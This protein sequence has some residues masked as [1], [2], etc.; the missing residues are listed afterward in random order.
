MHSLC[1]IRE[2]YEP[3]FIEPRFIQIVKTEFRNINTH[4]KLIYFIFRTIESLQNIFLVQSLFIQQGWIYNKLIFS[5]P[6]L[7]F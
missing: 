3:V 2:Y 1:L 6:M 4:V 7:N 5:K